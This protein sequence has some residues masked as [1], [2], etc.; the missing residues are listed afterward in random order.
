MERKFGR[1]RVQAPAGRP[2]DA[3]FEVERY[4]DHQGRS[5][6]SRFDANSLLYLTRALDSFDLSER[7]GSLEASLG[8][9]RARFLLLTFSSDWLYPPAQLARLAAAARTVGRE[10]EY[11]CLESDRGHD[12][13]LLEH[14]QQTPVI[15]GFLD[16]AWLL[17]G[18]H[19]PHPEGEVAGEGASG[20]GGGL[21]SRDR[22]I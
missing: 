4:L 7:D 10:V 13:F 2:W 9:T 17:D 5:F 1:A 12:A 14:E 6:V 8:R 21:T 20:Q 11:R 16:P 22:A 3:E 18:R 19:A 15:R